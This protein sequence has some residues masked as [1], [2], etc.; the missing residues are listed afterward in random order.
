VSADKLN[1]MLNE[2]IRDITVGPG[3]SMM[4][5]PDGRVTISLN[6]IN[7]PIGMVVRRAKFTT[8]PDQSTD[9]GIL[10]CTSYAADGTTLASDEVP[11]IGMEPHSLN[12]D[13]LIWRP[14]GGALGREYNARRANGTATGAPQDYTYSVDDSTVVWQEFTTRTNVMILCSAIPDRAATYP[15]TCYWWHVRDSDFYENTTQRTGVAAKAEESQYWRS[16]VTAE[17]EWSQFSQDITPVLPAIWTGDY[18]SSSPTTPKPVFLTGFTPPPQN[19]DG[20]PFPDSP[21]FADQAWQ[22]GGTVT[23]PGTSGSHPS[24]VN[25]A[26]QMPISVPGGTRTLFVDWQGRVWRIST[27]S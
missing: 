4:R 5:T 20:F 27:R 26:I 21:G 2:S 10:L 3:L 24:E 1:R 6:E 19:T 13:L 12:D 7:G 11:V 18:D 9:P 14:P 25:G 22:R 17:N 8:F 23:N 16:G 15:Y